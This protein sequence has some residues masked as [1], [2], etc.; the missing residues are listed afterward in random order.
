MKQVLAQGDR[1]LKPAPGVTVLIYHRVGGGSGSEVDLDVDAFR[2]QLEHLREHHTVVSLDAAAEQLR[3]RQRR[4]AHRQHRRHHVRRRDRRLLRP[5]RPGARRVRDPGDALRG[6]PLHRPW[7]AVPLGRPSRQLAGPARRRRHRTR[8]HRLAHPHPRPARPRRHHRPR[9]PVDDR[10]R[11]RPVDRTD[12]RTHRHAT[13]PLRLPQGAPRLRRPPK[14]RYADA[15]PPPPSPAAASTDPDTPTSTGSGARRSSAATATTSSSPRPPA[16]CAWKANSATSSPR[17]STAAPPRDRTPL[18]TCASC[19]S[20]RGSTSAA[21]NAR[22]STWRSRPL[23]IRCRR[24]GRRGQLAARPPRTHPG[25]RRH[26]PAPARRHRP[27]RHQPPLAASRSSSPTPGSTS[28]TSTAPFPPSSPASPPAGA[29]WSPPRTHRGD[30]CDS[31][32]A[33]PGVPPTASTLQASPCPRP[34][35]RRCRHGPAA[36]PS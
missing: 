18:T 1:V 14:P 6:D 27:H 32:R 16:A 33:S 23:D 9:Q 13:R 25:D 31:R 34:S 8:H 7:R 4:G 35:P 2:A 22:S 21:S 3:R 19:S 30:R 15:S 29:A 12:R 17:S 5:R 26:H 20:P 28:C 24:R 10:R 11:T 36:A